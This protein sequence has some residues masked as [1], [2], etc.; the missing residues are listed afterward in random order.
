MKV[1]VIGATGGTGRHAV[2]KLLERGREVTAWARRPSSVV[3]EGI[4]IASAS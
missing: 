1:L 2:R 3:A 4:A